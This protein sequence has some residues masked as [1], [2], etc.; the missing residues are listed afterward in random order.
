MQYVQGRRKRS[1]IP[2]PESKERGSSPRL[3]ER[4]WLTTSP[5][6]SS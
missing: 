6:L 4:K 2:G 3:F 1:V 5:S